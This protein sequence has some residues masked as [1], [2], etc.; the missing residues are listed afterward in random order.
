MNADA[1]LTHVLVVTVPVAVLL[2][3][4]VILVRKRKALPSFLQLLGAGFLIVVV[5][6]H[7]CEA[8]HLLPSMGW[9]LDR[10][11]GHYLD[12]GSFVLGLTL[13]PLGYLLHALNLE[14]Q[15]ETAPEI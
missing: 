4:S 3:G 13:F 6:A 7:L 11:P 10:S 8:L 12:G 9:G 5:F 2:A 15:R 1:Q 14:P